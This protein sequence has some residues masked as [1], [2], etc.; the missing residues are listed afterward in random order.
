MPPAP[1]L[2]MAL[3]VIASLALCIVVMTFGAV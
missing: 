2:L 1:N 3:V